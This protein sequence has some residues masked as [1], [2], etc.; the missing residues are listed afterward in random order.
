M[1]PQET[2]LTIQAIVGSVGVVASVGTAGIVIFLFRRLFENQDKLTQA[3]DGLVASVNDFK[4]MVTGEYVAC[5][6]CKDIREGCD[7]R[8]TKIEK[9]QSE[10][11]GRM[12]EG[13]E[14]FAKLE[15]RVDTM[16]FKLRDTC[17]R[18]HD[19]EIKKG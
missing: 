6:D 10:R 19:L 14:R 7:K 9:K 16:D 2:L 5:D 11:D 17:N 12:A 1:N 13:G 18:V 15:S 3:L 4:L 8:L